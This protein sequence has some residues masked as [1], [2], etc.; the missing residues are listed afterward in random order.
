LSLFVFIAA[1]I[2][3]GVRMKWS[4]V[5]FTAFLEVGLVLASA[6]LQAAILFMM[7]LAIE[8]FARRHYPWL[9]IGW[10][11]LLAGRFRDAAVG[12][13]VLVGTALGLAF[14]LPMQAR[15]YDTTLAPLGPTYDMSFVMNASGLISGIASLI[16]DIVI[17]GMQHIIL[18]LLIRL[19]FRKAF[20]LG[21][22]LCGFLCALATMWVPDQPLQ[23]VLWAVILA[24]SVPLTL[25]VG[26]LAVVVGMFV[27]AVAIL[28]PVSSNIPAWQMPYAVTGGLII[29]LIALYGF[30]TALAGRA[31]VPRAWL[32]P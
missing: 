7:Y 24:V 30:Y 6:L 15:Y 1:L 32:A 10:T 27:D 28:L 29:V 17:G 14:T 2:A 12:R 19:A 26:F 3:N 5:P 9:M 22:L 11:R 4:P 16:P 25:R 23:A 8:L 13:E 20:T 21:L 18:V 31:L